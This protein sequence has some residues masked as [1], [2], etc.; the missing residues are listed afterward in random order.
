MYFALYYTKFITL[1]VNS[2][3]ISRNHSIITRIISFTKNGSKQRSIVSVYGPKKFITMLVNCFNLPQSFNYTHYLFYKNGSKQRSIV[4]VYR[5]RTSIHKANLRKKIE[6]LILKLIRFQGF[7]QT[8]F[9]VSSA[10]YPTFIGIDLFTIAQE[11][12]GVGGGDV[13]NINYEP[14]IKKMKHEET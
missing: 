5:P 2:F 4:S 6:K 1:L 7:S 3:L 13:E 9:L 11:D 14:R 8:S 12:T 10:V